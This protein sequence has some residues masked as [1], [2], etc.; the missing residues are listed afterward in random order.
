MTILEK[1]KRIVFNE[2]MSFAMYDL[3]AGGKVEV[4]GTLEPGTTV[5]LVNSETGERSTPPAGDHELTEPAGT[6]IVVDEN[7]VI[8]AV[9]TTDSPVATT[10]QLSEEAAAEVGAVRSEIVSEVSEAINEETPSEVTPELATAIAEQVVSI[11]ED[12]VAEVTASQIEEMRK[13]MEKM[14]EILMEMAKTQKKFSSDVDTLKKSPSGTPLSKTK[15][16]VDSP[17]S[18]LADQRA[19]VIKYLKSRNK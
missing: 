3:V 1:I 15:F 16:E 5:Y 2:A 19:E 13:R 8:T 7:G 18:S 17:V 9:K 12:K 14:E 11:V 10:E 6:T 4:D